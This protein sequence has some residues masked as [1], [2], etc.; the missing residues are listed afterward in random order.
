MLVFRKYRSELTLLLILLP[1]WVKCSQIGKWK[2]FD[3]WKKI[4][5]SSNYKSYNIETRLL[6]ICIDTLSS[7]TLSKLSL[8]FEKHNL[9]W[10]QLIVLISLFSLKELFVSIERVKC[11]LNSRHTL[12]PVNYLHAFG[13]TIADF[14]AV[15][16]FKLNSEILVVLYS[17]FHDCFLCDLEWLEVIS[18]YYKTWLIEDSVVWLFLSLLLLLN[19]NEICKAVR[20]CPT[21]ATLLH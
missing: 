20:F 11:Y 18:I 15:F 5:H 10:C 3:Y 9:C 6:Y 13:D 1:I 17:F 14:V 2:C 4:S 21:K 16:Y 12:V 19:K 7:F 8:E